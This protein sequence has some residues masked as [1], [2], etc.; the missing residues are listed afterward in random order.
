MKTT[1]KETKSYQDLYERFSD[2]AP[3]DLDALNALEKILEFRRIDKDE[4]LSEIYDNTRQIGFVIEGV[5][6]A[7]H[8]KEDGTERNKNFFTKN[9]LFMTSLDETKDLS[10]FIQA[11]TECEVVLFGYDA[12]MAL[13]THHRSL[14]QVFN[15]VLLEYM[16]R[17]QQREI[18]LLTLEAKDRY[19]K[20]IESN[21][22]LSKKLP[23]YH[24]ASYLGITPTQLSRIKKQFNHQHM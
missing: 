16:N 14:E 9:D 23:Q 18:E 8:L 3:I 4:Y 20:F 13:S 7:Y 2:Y 22:E 24:I 19:S 10:V 5:I 17:K 11:I 15:K 6:R 21:M 12:F 1:Q